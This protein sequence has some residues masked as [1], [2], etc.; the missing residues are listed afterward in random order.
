MTSLPRPPYRIQTGSSLGVLDLRDLR[1][2]H[3]TQRTSTGTPTL[4]PPN[5][6][7]LQIEVVRVNPSAIRREGFPTTRIGLFLGF[8]AE[9]WQSGKVGTANMPTFL[10]QTITN[11]EANC[12]IFSMGSPPICHKSTPSTHPHPPHLSLPTCP[13]LETRSTQLLLPHRQLTSA[14]ACA[15][16]PRRRGTA[17]RSG[18]TAP[19]LWRWS[20]E[21]HG[22]N[23]GRA[24]AQAQAEI[25]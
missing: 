10:P 21:R 24:A 7:L 3:I 8:G 18:A 12:D 1:T 20:L 13:S 23:R 5:R 15:R 9:S 2:L 16:D 22:W 19:W 25:P 14:S 4:S 11:L 17:P 6:G